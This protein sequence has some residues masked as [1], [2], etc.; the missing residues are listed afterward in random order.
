[1]AKQTGLGDNFYVAGYD[2]SGDVQ[3]LGNISCPMSP[4]DLTGI[5]KSAYERAG[6]ARDGLMEF[7]TFF[8]DATSAEH[9]ALK[10]LPTADVDLMY[11]RGTTLGNAGA[12]MRGKQVNYDLN[13][14][15]DGS[16]TF[17]VQAV[18]NA[19]GL[20]WGQL[21]TAGK[22]TDTSA[23]NGSSI[24]TTASASF[25]WQMYLQAFALTGTSCTVT[26]EDS[27]DNAAWTTLSGAAFTA[28]TGRGTERKASAS[29]TATVRRYL[30]AVTSGT[31]SSAIFAVV[32]I[33]NENLSVTF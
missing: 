23:T 19:Y 15:D 28:F 32:F 21:L 10:S 8:N 12:A 27:A 3:S 4:L 5:D 33:K 16:L 20:E 31:F 25:G 13:R 29:P 24:D 2:V 1:M 11:C 22:R 14:G 9:D 18:A 6:G 26:I 30:R 17:G 7:T